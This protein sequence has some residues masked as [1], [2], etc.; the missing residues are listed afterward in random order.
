[1]KKEPKSIKK[2]CIA[3][4]KRKG[5]DMSN[6]RF[7]KLFDN[8]SE[9]E[10]QIYSNIDLE[11]NELP[12]FTCCQNVENWTLVTTH[13]LRGRIVKTNIKIALDDIEICDYGIFKLPDGDPIIKE[14]IIRTKDLRE[15]KMI[16]ESQDAGRA[17]LYAVEYVRG[18]RKKEITT[19]S[20]D[21]KV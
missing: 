11:R 21:Y 9:A 16:Q 18:S 8:L 3:T 10:K 15:F 14:M 6:W 13:F 12:I 1:M 7:S 4:I 2:I 19:E 20:N 5:G 17:M